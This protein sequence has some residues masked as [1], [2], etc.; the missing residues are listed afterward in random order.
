MQGTTQR[1][2]CRSGLTSLNPAATMLPIHWAPSPLPT[3]NMS[4]LSSTCRAATPESFHK[5]GPR[6]LRMMSIQ[7]PMDALSPSG[8]G[9]PRFPIANDVPGSQR[10]CLSCTPQFQS[11]PDANSDA[12]TRRKAALQHCSLLPPSFHYVLCSAWRR[13]RSVIPW[14]LARVTASKISPC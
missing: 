2:P 12:M 13:F 5:S 7:G 11:L 4:Q 9:I 14:P 6:E 10:E 3:A 1:T 8:S